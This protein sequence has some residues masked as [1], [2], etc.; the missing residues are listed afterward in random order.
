MSTIPLAPRPSPVIVEPVQ[1]KESPTEPGV[2]ILENLEPP[3]TSPRQVVPV[4]NAA[5]GLGI[6]HIEEGLHYIFRRWDDPALGNVSVGDVYSI[7]MNGIILAEG[8]VDVTTVNNDQF[9]L[10]IPRR[11]L[12]LGF[13]PNVYGEVRRVGSSVPAR[14]VPQVVFIKDTRP[15]GEDEIPG[16]GWHSKLVLTL[17]HT[18]IDSTVVDNV[19]GTIKAWENMRVNDSPRLSIG[20]NL[21]PLAPVTE[22]QV[23]SDLQFRIDPQFLKALDNGQYVAQFYLLD[24]VQNISGSLEHKSRPMLV[25]VNLE[26][27]EPLA[28]P[29]I[30]EADVASLTLDADALGRSPATASVFVARN[31]PNFLAGDLIRVTVR[32]TTPGG[33]FITESLEQEMIRGYNDF[34]I[35]NEL[36]RSLIQ[37]SLTVYSERVRVGVAD[38]GSKKLTVS[39]I[40][41]RYELP[42]PKVREAYGPFIAPDHL[43]ITV[44]MPDYQ[45]P[46]NP[47]DNLKV[48]IQG[49]RMDGTVERVS[50]TRLAG[51][52]VRTRDFINAEYVKFEG[53]ANTNVH[54]EVSGA[55]D[56]RESERL[57]VQ[58][59]RAALDL[60]API[61]HEAVNGNVDP[62]TVGSVGTLELRTEFKQGDIIIVKYTGSSS[63]VV[64]FQYTL[65]APP[66]N[67]LLLD[68]PRQLFL[69]NLDGTLT[70]SY[71]RDRF[72]AAQYSEDLLVTI[73]TAL[74]ELFAPQV[75]EATTDPDEL[76]SVRCWPAGATVRVRYDQIKRMDK[77]VMHL[78]GLPEEGTYSQSKDNQTGDFIDFTVPTPVIGFNLHPLGR[79]IKVFF[80]VIRNGFATDSPVLEVYLLPPRQLAGPIIDSI[81]DSAVLEVPLLQDFDETRVPAW[82]YPFE[83]QRMWFRYVGVRSN[84]APYLNEVYRGRDVNAD[85]VLNGITSDTP[86]LALRNLQEASDLKICFWV[87]FNRTGNFEDAVPFEVRYHKIQLQQNIF[88]H[89]N[90]KDSIP[91]TG[92]VVSIDPLTVENKCQV[93]VSYPDMNKGGTDRITLHWIFAD[94]TQPYISPQNGLDG[95]TVTFNINNVILGSSVNSTVSLQYSVVL[96]GGGEGSSEVQKVM[97]GSLAPADLPRVL[98]NYIP[99]GGSINPPALT[100]NALAGSPKWR[101]SVKDQHVW[102]TITTN[103]PGVAPLV[104]LENHPITAIEQA[105]GLANVPVSRDWLQSLANDARITVRTKVNYRPGSEDEFLAVDFPDTEYTISLTSPLVIDQTY[106]YLDGTTYILPDYPT[107]LPNF[108]SGNS[109]RINASGGTPPYRYSSSNSAVAVV[110]TT[111]FVSLRGNGEC[112]ITVSDSASPP[113]TRNCTVSG[114]EVWH[115]YG[116]GGGTLSDI[117]SRAVS[118]GLTSVYIDELESINAAYGSRWPMGNANYWS[119]SFSHKEYGFNFYYGLNLVTGG[120][121]AV[122][123]DNAITKPLGIGVIRR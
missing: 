60:P 26:D 66:P 107:I 54:Y 39:V 79:I 82:Q 37:S 117:R 116:L 13:I 1:P 71:L 59:G 49:H 48:E 86:V 5:Y 8:T 83:G 111:G 12:Q 106:V 20:E 22:S 45:P 34:P 41:R 51:T 29:E 42:K 52:H 28:P 68:I 36:V 80:K 57:Y 84:G 44:E 105:N 58:I 94:G 70:V 100:G 30:V 104:L 14:S 87:T 75:L 21:Y 89:P 50:S 73:G 115:V 114:Y 85:E 99:H 25:Q 77:V 15:G 31:D 47:G 16:D 95:G 112:V 110:D 4:Q 55:N 61:I 62:A 96:A 65:G 103:S 17:S 81:G 91:A 46:G 40:G 35:R 121:R 98:I 64:Q 123:Q 108:N 24:E 27:I 7:R 19:T 93:M 6:R 118:R 92:A 67:P 101:L 122:L 78:D 38:L 23:G 63:G 11:F 74:G 33:E 102:S 10:T 43:R 76:D 90:I 119:I 120:P 3:S 72:G 56:V 32:G 88:P 18:V 109:V 97:V 69:D 53:L 2:M 9:Y 113:Q